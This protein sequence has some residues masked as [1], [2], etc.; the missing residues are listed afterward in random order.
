MLRHSGTALLGAWPLRAP[1]GPAASVWPPPPRACL[2]SGPPQTKEAGQNSKARLCAGAR[3]TSTHE[4]Y[5]GDCVHHC[6]PHG[7]ETARLRRATFPVWA[8]TCWP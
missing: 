2:R 1:S 4:L 6:V 3:G 8:S 7:G 5:L